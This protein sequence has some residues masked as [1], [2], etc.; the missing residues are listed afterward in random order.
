[1]LGLG[2]RKNV[3]SDEPYC[4]SCGRYRNEGIG[5]LLRANEHV[6]LC[7]ECVY[8]FFYVVQKIE[9]QREWLKLRAFAP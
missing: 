5:M 8:Q 6:C 4:G 9:T 2:S 3:G 1:V 7:D